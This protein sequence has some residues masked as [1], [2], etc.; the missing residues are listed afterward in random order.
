MNG[1]QGAM[2][3]TQKEALDLL[4]LYVSTQQLQ[5]MKAGAR[6]EEKAYFQ[7]KIVEM[8]TRIA[9]MPKTYEQ[10]GKGDKATVSLHYFQGSSDWYILEK[11]ISASEDG[12]FQAFGFAVLNGDRQNAELGYIN[13]D[14]LTRQNVELDLHFEPTTLGVIKSKHQ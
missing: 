14:E 13:I 2:M 5:A 11:D 12:N 9:T 1:K 3:Q 8:G 6:G 7:G 10:D 4:K